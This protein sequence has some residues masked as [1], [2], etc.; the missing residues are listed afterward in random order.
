M[1]CAIPH[2][3]LA[4]NR[5]YNL[6]QLFCFL[7][8][9]NLAGLDA[10]SGIIPAGITVRQNPQ[11][12]TR[13]QTM[14]CSTEEY[15]IGLYVC[16]GELQHRTLIH[17]LELPHTTTALGGYTSLYQPVMH[18]R[19]RTYCSRHT[20]GT[21]PGFAIGCLLPLYIWS[22]QSCSVQDPVTFSVMT[23]PT[24]TAGGANYN[25]SVVN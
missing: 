16:V 11:A 25:L 18:A 3:S 17:C 20:S 22:I 15:T 6:W 10:G 2:L 7:A 23:F 12:Y 4:Q 24:T 8:V 13:A 9:L 19:T 21:S 1:C 14:G 5:G